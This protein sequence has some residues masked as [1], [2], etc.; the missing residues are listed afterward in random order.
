VELLEIKFLTIFLIFLIVLPLR[1]SIVSKEAYEASATTEIIL[2]DKKVVNVHG[3]ITFR[4]NSSV[5]KENVPLTVSLWANNFWSS[6][7]IKKTEPNAEIVYAKYD[8]KSSTYIPTLKNDHDSM[9]MCI[10]EADLIPYREVR[11]EVWFKMIIYKVDESAITRE[12]VGTV[13]EIPE[14][15][16]LKYAGETYYWDYNSDP[17]QRTIMEIN[18][19]IGGSKNVYD[20]VYGTLSWFST[21]MVYLEREDYPYGRVKASKILNETIETPLGPRHYGVCRHFSDVFIAVMRG[22]GI[23]CNLYYGLI[24]ANYGG[25]IGLI[26]E[27]GHAWC[28]VYMPKL[29]W[30]PVEVTISD[31]YM[32]DVVRVGLISELYYLPIYKEYTNGKPKR[33]VEPYEFVLPSYWSWSIEELEKS[34]QQSQVLI[35]HRE[36]IQY[37]LLALIV[38]LIV[39][40]FKLKRKVEELSTPVITDDY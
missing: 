4:Y 21:H 28:E 30:I 2:F 14:E 7:V 16:R 1:P 31:R 24:F 37:I 32:R 22:F 35:V 12:D 18:A 8:E 33:P 19:S 23:P 10:F 13:N 20:I 9:L 17:V 6:I 36:V 26:F 5:K 40:R 27:G 34:K 38:Y 25:K 39:D 3:R 11:V 29:G 15:L